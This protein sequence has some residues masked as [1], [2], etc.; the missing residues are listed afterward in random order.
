MRITGN[1]GLLEITFEDVEFGA[2][3]VALV[4]T[5]G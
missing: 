1:T 5:T 4:L 3:R 2:A